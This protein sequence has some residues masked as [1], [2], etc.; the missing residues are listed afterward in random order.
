MP[1]IISA[2]RAA[3]PQ[4]PLKENTR[5]SSQ[6]ESSP[7]MMRIRCLVLVTLLASCAPVQVRHTQE[8]AAPAPNSRFAS[9]IEAFLKEDR[10]NPPPQQAI[11]FIGSSIFRLWTHLTEQMAPLPVF[12]RAFGGSWTADILQLMDKVVLPYQPRIIVYYCGSNDING[13][14]KPVPIFLRV[15]QF[16]DRVQEKLPDTRI[17]YVSINR[18]PQKRDRWDIVDSTNALVK[19]YC[20]KGK[21]LAFIDVNPVLFDEENRPR[22]EFYQS[23]Q[24]HLTDQAYER[25]AAVIRPIIEK[26]CMAE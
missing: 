11:L 19:E 8:I 2:D 14:E 12:N 4:F 13:S 7:M 1:P 26:A 10:I 15:K 3:R 24:L 5:L 22:M 16:C 23:D 18:A 25:F 20:S 17:Y 9:E 6:E 21:N